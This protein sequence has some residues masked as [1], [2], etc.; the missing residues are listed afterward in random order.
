MASRPGVVVP[1]S[2]WELRR[3]WAR[4]R[5]GRSGRR[6][7]PSDRSRQVFKFCFISGPTTAPS[8]ARRASSS[9]LRP[10]AHPNLVEVY[11]VTEGDRPPATSRWSTSRGRRCATGSRRIRRWSDRLEIVAQIADALDTVHAAG[12][13]HRDIKPAN[14]LL[15]RRED[16][17]LQAKLRDFGLGA[18]E[19]QPESSSE[20]STASRVGR[21]APGRGDDISLPKSGEGRR[22]LGASHLYSLGVTLYQIAVGDLDGP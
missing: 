6:Y 4:A 21:R 8:S 2:S 22:R 17:V 13:Y 20:A 7:N 16:G 3:S 19:D 11:D 18:A 10:Y 1:E 5:L 12:I 9:G 14:I 15:T